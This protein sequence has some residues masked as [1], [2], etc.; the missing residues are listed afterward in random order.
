MQ[1][2]QDG[3]ALGALALF[4]EQPEQFFLAQLREDLI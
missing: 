4:V 2:R 1:P 3:D